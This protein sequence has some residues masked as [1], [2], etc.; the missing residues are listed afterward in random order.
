MSQKQPLPDITDFHRLRTH[1]LKLIEQ[2]SSDVWTDYNK[3]D[4]GITIL[5][6]LCYGLTDL[7]YRTSHDIADLLSSGGSAEAHSEFPPEEILPC[8][9]I[10]LLDYRKLIVDEP[11]VQNAWLETVSGNRPPIYYDAD[12]EALTLVPGRKVIDVRGF[13]KVWY[14][15]EEGVT[16]PDKVHDRIASGLNANRNLCELFRDI[17]PIPEERIGLCLDLELDP[18]ADSEEVLAQIAYRIDRF[19]SPYVRFYHLDEMRAAG[20]A[21]ED[22]YR[23]PRLKHGFILDHELAATDLKKELHTSDMLNMAMDIPGVRAVKRILLTSYLDPKGLDYWKP[24]HK[25]RPWILPLTPGAAPRLWWKN[26]RFLFYKNGIPYAPD[27]VQAKQRLEELKSEDRNRKRAAAGGVFPR[28]VGKDRRTETYYSIQ[29]EFP[30]NYG[31]GREGLPG[32]APDERKARAKQ[33]KAYLLMMEQVLANYLAQ[34]S[35]LRTILSLDMI[36]KTVFARVP[37]DIPGLE[38]LLGPAGGW[39][40]LEL[41]M[42]D[43]MQDEEQFLQQRA[44]MLHHL[45]ARFGESFADY[46]AV[47]VGV[48]DTRN[49]LRLIQDMV[50]FL[51]RYP[52]FSGRRAGAVDI[53]KAHIGPPNLPGLIQRLHALLGPLRDYFVMEKQTNGKFT[54]YLKSDRGVKIL[55]VKLRHVDRQLVEAAIGQVIEFGA[56]P[57]NYVKGITPG[58]KFFFKLVNDSQQEIAFRKGNYG[59]PEARDAA[60]LE[61]Q[62]FFRDNPPAKRVYLLEDTCWPRFIPTGRSCRFVRITPSPTVKAWTPIRSG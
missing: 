52:A 6:H 49:G 56:D 62:T 44:A 30:L 23:G 53:A 12:Q 47:S 54:A 1:G 39:P 58:N 4:P 19:I 9:P 29:H 32:R 8:G 2:Y 51:S 57:A 34:L 50:R 22:I 14:Q 55:T 42:E 10:T 24:I 43:L 16:D 48:G 60:L 40:D 61:T 35:Q 13:Y 31:L 45:L 37:N 38:D 36:D 3:H 25:G 15:L 21:M 41:A 33:L 11:G 20:Y 5:E 26:S 28:P 18:E 17:C 7:G 46:A 27:K 59:T